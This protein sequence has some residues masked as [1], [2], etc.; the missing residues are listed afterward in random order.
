VSN[1]VIY[2][3]IG[4]SDD[5]LGQREWAAFQIDVKTVLR[6]HRVL[7]IGEWHSLPDSSFQNACFAIDGD[8][9]ELPEI[10]GELTA[11]AKIYHQDSIA[12]AVAPDTVF[13]GR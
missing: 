5:K 7:V 6:K 3:G 4:N 13:L 12:W 1:A 11:L 9:P 2:I 8:V 10:Q